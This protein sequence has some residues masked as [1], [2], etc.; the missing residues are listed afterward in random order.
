M[1]AEVP[2]VLDAW[3]MVAARR[4]FDGRLPLAAMARLRDLLADTEGEACFSLEFGHDALQVPF[5]ALRVEA[6]LPLV[7]QRTLQRFVLPVVIDQRFALV[8]DAS[9]DTVDA[10]LLPGYEALEIDADGAMRPADLVEDELILAVP[11]VPAVP[12]SEAVEC[13]WAA[14]AEEEAVANPFAALAA[15][16]KT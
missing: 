9:D 1:S 13:D 12:G 11:L 5:A 2:D 7:C 8:R 14:T 15:L 16:K 6:G 10:S 3:R 4:C